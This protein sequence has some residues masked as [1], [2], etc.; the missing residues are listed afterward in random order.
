[1]T[2]YNKQTY[3]NFLTLNVMFICQFTFKAVQETI[4]LY[5]GCATKVYTHR[6]NLNTQYGTVNT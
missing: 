6:H 3:S 5:R 1:M 2:N 4:I